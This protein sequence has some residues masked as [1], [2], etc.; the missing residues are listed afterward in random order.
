MNGNFYTIALTFPVEELKNRIADYLAV[1]EISLP[2]SGES[3]SPRYV[4][5]ER[6]DEFI[7]AHLRLAV[8]EVAA[9][10]SG[11]DATTDFDAG[12]YL[13]ITLSLG[14]AVDA[15]HNTLLGEVVRDWICGNVVERALRIMSSDRS[16]AEDAAEKV[17]A[18][19]QR[20]MM[21][22]CASDM[23]RKVG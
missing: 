1:R 22:L 12:D 15:A 23:L 6:Q 10:L 20:L 7:E 16:L 21:M 8:W 4:G 19:R 14:A 3:N 2:A 18:A 11:W 9:A 13:S 17:A 5:D